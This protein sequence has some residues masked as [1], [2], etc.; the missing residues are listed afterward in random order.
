MRN[1]SHDLTGNS[2]LL[3]IEPLENTFY[4]SMRERFNSQMR[5]LIVSTPRVVYE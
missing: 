1:L 3:A 4:M 2:P 5:F